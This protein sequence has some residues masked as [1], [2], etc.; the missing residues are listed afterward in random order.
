M[1]KLGV[2]QLLV[3]VWLLL[4]LSFGFFYAESLL[5]A[6]ESQEET[7][8]SIKMRDSYLECGL[9]AL[10]EGIIY[11]PDA[12][13]DMIICQTENFHITLMIFKPET[14]SLEDPTADRTIIW[15]N[16]DWAFCIDALDRLD[17]KQLK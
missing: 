4:V 11:Y 2:W 9:P 6:V 10:S 13:G 3:L 16:R 17:V 1:G 15:G 5:E 12:S 7:M 8:E 14:T